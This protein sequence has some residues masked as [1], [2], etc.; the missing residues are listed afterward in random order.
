MINKHHFQQSAK[1]FRAGRLTLKEFTDAVF[2]DAEQ[3]PQLPEPGL[4][5]QVKTK[6]AVTIGES[7]QLIPQLP[8]RAPESHKGDFGRV[9]LIGGSQGMAGAISL[10]GLAALRSG[11][12]LVKVIVPD[13]IQTTVAGLT[14]CYMTVGCQSTAEGAFEPVALGTIEDQIQWSDVVG[15]GPGM[16]RGPAQKMIAAKLFTETPQPMVVDA[17]GLN[18][19]VDGEVDLSKHAGQRILTP[20]PGEFQRLVGAKIM[21]RKEL[22]QRAADLAKTMRLVI[23]LK[24]HHTFVTDGDHRFHNQTG[25]PGMATAG[26]GDVLTG[27]VTSLVGQGLSLFDAA[28]VGV[29]VHGLAGDLMAKKSGEA[30]LIA[31]D[32]IDG[33]ADSFQAMG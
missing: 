20:H 8:P 17:D 29:H 9:V 18:S 30:S 4:D 12:G 13:R 6:L 21:D 14:P 3:H 11:S 28:V 25:N 32:L 5:R 15:L 33:L 16:A 26:A 27:I 10:S 24:G 23:V 19:L 1:A 31:S 2:A 7:Q 22:E